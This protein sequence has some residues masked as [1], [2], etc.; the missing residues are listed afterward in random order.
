MLIDWSV[1]VEEETSV[2]VMAMQA[3]AVL[4]M[5]VVAVHQVGSQL[6]QI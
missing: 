4:V 5:V 2:A 1:V 6:E 3:W